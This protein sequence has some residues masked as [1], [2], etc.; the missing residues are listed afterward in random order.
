[1][2]CPVADFIKRIRNCKTKAEER[3][4]VQKEMAAIRESLRKADKYKARSLAKL[5][6][7][8]MMG[9]DTDFGQMVCFDLLASDSFIEKRLGYLGLTQFFHEKSDLLISSTNKIRDDLKKMNR[10]ETSLALGVLG[11]ICSSEMAKN[12]A[13]EVFKIALSSDAFIQKKALLVCSRMVRKS[14]DL[15]PDILPKLEHLFY[16]SNDAGVLLGGMG[17]LDSIFQTEEK[18]LE[19]ALPILPMMGQICKFQLERAKDM[20]NFIMVGALKLF[21]YFAKICN[22]SGLDQIKQK[23]V[24]VCDFIERSDHRSTEEVTLELI[25][26]VI[27]MECFESLGERAMRLMLRFLEAKD[28]NSKYLALYMIEGMTKLTQPGELIRHKE[29]VEQCF[30]EKDIIIK[31]K[32]LKIMTLITVKQHAEEVVASLLSIL[33][34]EKDEEFIPELGQSMC[35][36]VSLCPVSRRW[37]LDNMLNVMQLAAQNTRE[38][39]LHALIHVIEATP[40]LKKHAVYSTAMAAACHEGNEGL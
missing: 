23:L 16:P 15:I 28:A 36:I 20:N 25:R 37:Q 26:T 17:L 14:P 30:R 32:A 35:Q 7:I 11:E 10:F 27:D 2:S 18:F 21:K 38:D 12:L 22:R 40:E 8:N 13:P 6:F 24:A 3:Q 29:L 5:I 39:S 34:S 9:E 33:L 31:R 19:E 4:E 1:M